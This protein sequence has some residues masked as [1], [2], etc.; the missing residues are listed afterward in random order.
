MRENNSRT[1]LEKLAQ[2]KADLK[3]QLAQLQRKQRRLS[4]QQ[5]TLEKAAKKA[6]WE[7]AGKVC[8]ELGLPVDDLDALRGILEA[9]IH[10][11][12]LPRNGRSD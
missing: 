12:A 9:V 3:A 10:E 6:Q 11:I 7:A 2:Q 1:A 4:H 8:A 5:R